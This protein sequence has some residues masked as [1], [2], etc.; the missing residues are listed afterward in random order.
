MRASSESK[1]AKTLLLE[2]ARVREF[3]CVRVIAHGV[4]LWRDYEASGGKR[5]SLNLPQDC[6]ARVS[7][8]DGLEHA[9]EDL[10]DGEFGGVD[11][12]GVV[13]DAERRVVARGVALV[14]RR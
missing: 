3:L 6:A 14:A 9:F 11:D 1:R 5:S 10:F 4:F 12:D 13:G 8:A 2:G 7:V